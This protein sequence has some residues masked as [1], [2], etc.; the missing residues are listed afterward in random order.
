L[1]LVDEGAALILWPLS[2]ERTNPEIQT[3][4]QFAAGLTI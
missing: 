2:P 3:L 1:S 4:D